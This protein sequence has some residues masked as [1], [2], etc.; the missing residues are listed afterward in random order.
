MVVGRSLQLDFAALA[1]AATAIREGARFLATNTDATFPTGHGLE[2]GAGALVAFLAVA[3]GHQPEVAGKPHQPAAELLKARFGS[4]GVVVGDRP[5]TDGTFA[6]LIGA[7]FALVLSGVTRAEDLPVSPAARPGR[8]GPGRRRGGP[9]GL[10][11]GVFCRLQTFASTP[12]WAYHAAWRATTCSAG[13][14][15]WAPSSSRRR[16][17]GPRSSC[18]E[19]AQMGDSTQM[20]AQDAVDDLVEGGRKG[21]G[22]IL[23]SIRRE[24][25]AQLSQ[26]GLATKDDLA[27][28]EGRLA[29]GRAGPGRRR[30]GRPRRRPAPGRP[31]RQPGPGGPEGSRHH[32]TG[33]EGAGEESRGRKAAADEATARRVP[34]EKAAPAKKAPGEV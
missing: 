30:S 10:M 20:Q 9:S 22:Q 5:D 18:A 33:Q 17:P 21:T 34:G 4:A 16:G 14:R 31:R 12:G 2:P 8:T 1:A 3:S 32:G 28:L 7:P 11:I 23:T 19:L 13:I 29:G 24:I 6:Q 27:D 26:L 25:T 15:R